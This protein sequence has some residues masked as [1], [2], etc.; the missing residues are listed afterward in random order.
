[1]NIR[2]AKP[3]DAPV[4]TEI[5]FAAKRHWG[6]SERWIACWRDLLTI[7]PVF[8]T[9]HETYAAVVGGRIE[10]LY[11]LG[12]NGQRLEMA[13]LWVPPERIGQG[14]GR[15]LFLHALARGRALGYDELEIES[16]PNAEGF[17]RR[18]GARRVRVSI[19]Q[20][21]GERRELPVLLCPVGDPIGAADTACP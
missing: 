12:L 19:G 13:H 1:M 21:D 15:T 11:A 10:G 3:E 9:H 7:T 18:M 16:D 4:L 20:V 2:R 8:V 6:Y 14:V 5:G 17:Y